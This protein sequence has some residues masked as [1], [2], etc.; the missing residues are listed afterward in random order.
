MERWLAKAARQHGLLSRDQMREL[1]FTL[2]AIEWKLAAATIEEVLPGVFLVGGATL[3]WEQ[4]L[5]AACL[6]GGPGAV[7]SHASAAALW[8]FG[9]F[10]PGPVEISTLKQN[11]LALPLRVHRTEVDP[12]FTTGKSGIPVTNA[13]RTVLDVVTT[14]NDYRA[15]QLFD[16]ALRKGLVS[17]DSCQRLVEREAG[18]GRRGV[19]VLRQLVEQRSYGLS[20]VGL[21]GPGGGPPV[22]HGSRPRLHRGV[23]GQRLRRQLRG[24]GGLQACRFAAGRRDRWTAN[25]SS[26]VDWEQDLDRRNRIVAEGY[27][28]I[29]A[30]PDKVFRHPEELISEVHR[31]GEGQSRRRT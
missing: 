9:G 10:P 3:S 28:V 25:H 21:R 14:V 27:G 8:G 13:H 5:M 20:A 23:R 7:V 30:T 18:H 15:N 31:A 1:G 2:R 29:H 22:A 16:E 6:W 17:M 26:K 11:R 19:A 24:A 12:A 4:R